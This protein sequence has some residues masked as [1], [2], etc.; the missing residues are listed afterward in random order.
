[1]VAVAYTCNTQLKC[2]TLSNYV[3]LTCLISSNV[4]LRN[5]P[6]F[7]M[8]ET[9]HSCSLQTLCMSW[10]VHGDVLSEVQSGLLSPYAD[11]IQ[12][13]TDRLLHRLGVG[14]FPLHFLYAIT[15]ILNNMH[16]CHPGTHTISVILEKE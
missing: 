5:N 8:R 15:F 12:M 16:G 2:K 1:M 9:H 7:E 3:T 11:H 6:K 14:M 4:Y 10:E 13:S